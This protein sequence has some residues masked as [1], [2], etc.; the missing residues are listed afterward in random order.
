MI[1]YMRD[2][3]PQS[4]SLTRDDGDI[5]LLI[6]C[7][8]GKLRK[9]TCMCKMFCF[10]L[11]LMENTYLTSF[12]IDSTAAFYMMCTEIKGRYKIQSCILI[13]T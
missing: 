13:E 2:S 3:N 9:E 10:V 7:K 11:T 4:A 12:D 1:N 8:F 5:Y 6:S